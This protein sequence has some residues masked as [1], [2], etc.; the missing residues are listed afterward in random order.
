MVFS[1]FDYS[2]QQT[3]VCEE[4][5]DWGNNIGQVIGVAKE[6]KGSNTVPCRTPDTT[7][8]S[9][10]DWLS[11]TTYIEPLHTKVET[12]VWKKPCTPYESNLWRSMLWGTVSNAFDR[13]NIA[14]TIWWPL[15]RFWDRSFKVT[16]S[17]V[18]REY[19]FWSQDLIFLKVAMHLGTNDIFEHFWENWSK[20]YRTI[21]SRGIPITFFEYRRDICGEPIFWEGACVDRLLES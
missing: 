2:I 19:P 3:V 12:H 21:I 6:I 11:T 5:D 9:W 1:W 15:S 8:Y 14:T 16:A 20:L 18:S 17:W 7:G 10:E 4:S 13:S